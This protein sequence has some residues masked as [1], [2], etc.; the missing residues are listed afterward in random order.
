MIFLLADF[1]F[2]EFTFLPVNFLLVFLHVF[3][4]WIGQTCVT[5]GL[6]RSECWVSGFLWSTVDF[7]NPVEFHSSTR[8]G[9]TMRVVTGL[10]RVYV[11]NVGYK[12]TKWE[13]RP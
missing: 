12:R 3:Y 2:C 6:F 1:C 5:Y 7:L 8:A 10:P 11:E 4:F 13:P 9:S